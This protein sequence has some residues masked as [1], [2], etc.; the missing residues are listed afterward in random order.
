M[1]ESEVAMQK[2]LWCLPFLFVGCSTMTKNVEQ[3]VNSPSPPSLQSVIQSGASLQDGEQLGTSEGELEEDWEAELQGLS[4]PE[5]DVAK[6]DP[7]ER[8]NRVLY[9]MHRGVDL[10]FV[11][12]V[13]LTYSK[14]LPKPV[15][16]GLANFVSNLLAPARFLC[17]VLQGNW[18]EAGKTI[19]RF[20]TNTLLGFG[21]IIDV[22]GKMNTRETPTGFTE[23][24]KVWGMKP[25]PYLVVPG[26]GPTTFRGAL[27]FLLD[28]FLDPMFLL[29]LNKNLP[30]NAHHEL[31]YKD[32]GIQVSSLLISRS[33]IDSIYEDIEN[34]SVN[35]YSKLRGLVLQQPINR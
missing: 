32:T 1:R 2:I 31:V 5:I 14:V 35:R 20:A 10:L 6:S 30:A 7:F 25:G 3:E 11:R 18:E 15:Q 9:G 19:G 21:G 24:L 4:A 23:T 17:R 26:V 29:A 13:A 12:P 16:S 8:M 22:A 34:N 27:G 33:K 28:S